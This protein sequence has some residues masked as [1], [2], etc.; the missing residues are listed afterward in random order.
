MKNYFSLE[1]QGLLQL[2]THVFT[3]DK[4]LIKEDC[5]WKS[6][7]DWNELL[8]LSKNHAVRSLLYD[9]LVEESSISKFS[10]KELEVTSVQTVQQS[11]RLLF[12]SRGLTALLKENGI[13]SVVLKGSA[14]AEYY[15]VPE[16]R[17][18][19]DVDL[20]LLEPEKIEKACEVL[21]ENGYI[22]NEEQHAHH[23]VSMQSEENIEVE[24]HT[25]LAEPFDNEE[26]NRYIKELVTEC[27]NH[28]SMKTVM[29][30]DLPVLENGYFALHLLLHM[31]QHFLR[32]GFGIK[33]LCDWVVFWNH[34]QD[35][36]TK[37]T[38]L[39]LVKE[40]GLKGF[41]DMISAVCVYEL[42]LKKE[43]VRFMFEQ[44]DKSMPKKEEAAAFLRDILDAEEF[45]KS[46]K[47]R[48][49]MLRSTKWY[50]YIREFHH[51]MQLNFP[52]AGKIFVCWP[53][54]WMITLIRFLRNNRKL[55]GVSTMAVLK[56]AG[57]RSKIM[58]R[59][60]LFEKE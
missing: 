58:D 35:D 27:Q 33:L 54:L 15:P 24:L 55:R 45:G 53:V 60:R 30:M 22:I 10:R 1:E 20:L 19:G 28:W 12:L 6:A 47:D 59:I 17:K 21:Q 42:G 9:L 40:T 43:N 48:M 41:S 50:D 38:Y 5:A 2:L 4:N 26:I 25:M 11:Y 7:M 36:N 46:A 16:L 57:T 3:E 13:A 29:G 37:R 52:R 14:I 51:Q 8:R 18:S 31:L 34:L 32:A 56:K 23:H 44:G 49:V 39:R